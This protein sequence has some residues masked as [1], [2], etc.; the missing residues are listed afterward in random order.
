VVRQVV[1]VVAVPQN[2]EEAAEVGVEADVVPERVVLAWE[3]VQQC[4]Q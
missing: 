3:V 2:D 1:V 4:C